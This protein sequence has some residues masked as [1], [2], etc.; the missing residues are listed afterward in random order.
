MLC[1]D[2]ARL[3]AFHPGLLIVGVIAV[4]SHEHASRRL[5]AA[6]ANLA[7]DRVLLDALLGSLLILHCIAS[8]AVQQA[9]ITRAGAIDEIPL[10][11]EHD[12]HAT[13]REVA[14]DTYARST[15]ANHNDCCFFHGC[16]S[17]FYTRS[18]AP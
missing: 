12:I 11:N 10:L 13:H 2:A 4:E 16:G 17:T 7:E 1:L 3:A 8:A 18:F 14:Q 9:M 6:L 15:A 5:D